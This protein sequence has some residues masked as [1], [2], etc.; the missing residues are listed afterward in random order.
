MLSLHHLRHVTPPASTQFTND[1][2]GHLLAAAVELLEG[3]RL[4]SGNALP[5]VAWSSP[6][7]AT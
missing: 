1:D 3:R 2:T 5:Y 6:P 4:L 7:L